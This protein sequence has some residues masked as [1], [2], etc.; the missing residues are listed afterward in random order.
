MTTIPAVYHGAARTRT[1]LCV[2]HCTAGES[3]ASSVQWM[4]RPDNTS[5][6]SYH[7]LIDRDGTITAHCPDTLTAYHSGR[8]EWPNPRAVVPAGVSVNPRSLGIAF[9]NR[10]VAPGVKGFERIT[11]AQRAAAVTL[12]QSLVGRFPALRAA[13]AHVR[14]RD[15]APGRKVDPL[16][17]V[18]DWAAFVRTLAGALVVAA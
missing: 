6:A 2:W 10:D 12:L 7:Y 1:D 14:H 3:A 17:E 16:P 15:V 8:S 4:N 18:L 11:D 9:A 13:S 5:P